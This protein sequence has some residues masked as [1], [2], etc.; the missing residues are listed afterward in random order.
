MSDIIIF[1][2]EADIKET[3]FVDDNVDAKLIRQTI[4]EAMDI[5]IQPILGTTLFEEL[6]TQI[7]SSTLTTLNTTLLES[8][9]RFAL[10]YWTLYEGVD[11]FVYKF[12]NKG[13]QKQTSENGLVIDTDELKR[14]M[15]R[16]RNK[17]EWYSERVTKYLIENETSYPSYLNPDSGI[18]VIQPKRNNYT[19][20][21]YLGGTRGRSDKYPPS[22][23]DC[24]S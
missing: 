1:I 23:E 5:H 10:I 7:N 11:V 20:G 17:A 22:Q 19:T 24:C 15:D 13:V 3:T 8:Y 16:F 9:V 4:R 6:K 21:W 12:R 18:D 14:L 2:T